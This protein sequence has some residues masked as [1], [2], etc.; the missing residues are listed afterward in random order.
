MSY[1]F[2]RFNSWFADK[3]NVS[4]HKVM[5]SEELENAR[6]ISK[7]A[8]RHLFDENE[9]GSFNVFFGSG[10]GIEFNSKEEY[11]DAFNIKNCPEEVY[12]FHKETFHEG[13]FGLCF[14]FPLDY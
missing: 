1:Y 11:W 9:R 12:K 13:E 2:V 5:T 3:F 7:D 14:P 10:K 8:L 4:G 6:E